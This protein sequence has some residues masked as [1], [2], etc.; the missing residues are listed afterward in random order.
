MGTSLVSGETK[1]RRHHSR[2]IMMYKIFNRLVDIDPPASLTRTNA[3]TRGHS[4]R[5]LEYSC[6]C[7]VYASSF[8]PRTSRDWNALSADPL[9]ASV[10]Q[11]T[12]LRTTSALTHHLITVFFNHVI[13]E[14]WHNQPLCASLW[15]ISKSH[16]SWKMKMEGKCLF[17]KGVNFGYLEVCI[18]S[19]YCWD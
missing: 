7:H 18:E 8:Y 4:S 11:S 16:I 15:V 19:C 17:I 1:Q 12:H 5:I 14:P 9:L 10:N 6:S 13:L 3:N 2:L